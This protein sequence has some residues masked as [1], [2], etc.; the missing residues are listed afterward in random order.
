MND[1]RKYFTILRLDV[2]KEAYRDSYVHEIE[3]QLASMTVAKDKA[4]KALKACESVLD[5]NNLQPSLY[6]LIADLKK[7]AG[8]GEIKPKTCRNCSAWYAGAMD[9]LGPLRWHLNELIEE[10]ESYNRFAKRIGDPLLRPDKVAAAR[11]ANDEA[12]KVLSIKTD[13][14]PTSGKE[15]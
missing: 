9:V 12:D 10:M 11:K 4:L 3:R 2:G 7:V 5:S 13:G 1:L 6:K 15:R 14:K 8:K